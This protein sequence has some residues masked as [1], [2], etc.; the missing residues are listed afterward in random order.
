MKPA[1]TILST[2]QILIIILIPSLSMGAGSLDEIRN[3]GM[4]FAECVGTFEGYQYQTKTKLRGISG[5]AFRSSVYY[6]SVISITE[7]VPTL[8]LHSEVF[9]VYEKTKL[10][11][12][13]DKSKE[14]DT[15]MSNCNIDT[16]LWQSELNLLLR[17]KIFDLP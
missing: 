14:V 17:K 9:K 11:M 8:L 3:V 15:I 4:K 1:K 12:G 6:V 7:G 2:L 13:S 16:L 10:M 5:S